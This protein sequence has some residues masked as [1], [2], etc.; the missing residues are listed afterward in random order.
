MASLTSFPNELLMEISKYINDSADLKHLCLVSR[1]LYFVFDPV[2]YAFAALNHPHLMCWAS[3]A[4]RIETVKKLLLGGMSPN[5]ITSN[6]RDKD[7]EDGRHIKWA[8]DMA[9]TGAVIGSVMTHKQR[10]V[11][12]RSKQKNEP[13]TYDEHLTKRKRRRRIRKYLRSSV[14]TFWFSLHSAAMAGSTEITELLLDSG[15]QLDVPSRA[16]H[17]W[18]AYYRCRESS[19]KTHFWTPLH[20]ALCCGQEDVANLLITRG[21]SVDVEVQTR[22]SNAL[23][24]AARCGCLSTIR[25]LLEGDQK[26]PVDTRDFEGASPLMWALGTT[27]SIAT[28]KCLLQ[29][30]AN[31]DVLTHGQCPHHDNQSTALLRALRHCWYEDAGFLINSGANIHPPTDDLPSALDQC[32]ISLRVGYFDM[33]SETRLSEL[34]SRESESRKVFCEAFDV[35]S[36]LRYLS[37]YP[38]YND[39]TGAKVRIGMVGV[40][41]KLILHGANVHGSPTAES[42]PIVRAARAHLPE[43]VG[44]LLK[45]GASVDHEDDDGTYP[46]LAA[47]STRCTTQPESYIDTVACLLKNGSNPD[48][49][50]RVKQYRTALAALCLLQFD[51]P[52]ELEVAK[53]LVEHGADIHA[54]GYSNVYRDRLQLTPLQAALYSCKPDICRYLINKGAKMDPDKLDFHKVLHNLKSRFCGPFAL[55]GG[56]PRERVAEIFRLLVELDQSRS[57]M[58]NSMCFWMSITIGS[59]PLV[60]EFLDSGAS[61]ASWVDRF[62]QTCLHRLAANTSGELE[63]TALVPQLIEVGADVNMLDSYRRTPFTHLILPSSSARD[64]EES[65]EPYTELFKAFIE[66]GVVQSKWNIATFKWLMESGC[67]NSSTFRTRWAV[68]LGSLYQVK[69]GK[70][71]PREQRLYGEAL[72]LDGMEE[73]RMSNWGDMS[74]MP[75]MSG[76]SDREEDLFF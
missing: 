58:E 50:T 45:F 34:A 6:H 47:V 41:K 9:D 8:R 64:P 5:M 13:P 57:L 55:P 51:N 48:K 49:A 37:S 40:A 15:A 65:L 17:I 42:S 32:L 21:A 72:I 16:L 73:E 27:N 11:E 7:V 18:E 43:I 12:S 2:L 59:F 19:K 54:R 63:A 22:P 25:L 28:M 70:I 53:L 24:W 67:S 69:E 26:V 14:D 3:E 52:G 35:R 62:N 46:L 75:E 39:I 66:N 56:L 33:K 10:V 71:V 1:R 61:D 44:L 38:S 23:H 4:G 74:D 68:E 36:Q 60:K 76:L 29:Y 31:L 20:T 30:G